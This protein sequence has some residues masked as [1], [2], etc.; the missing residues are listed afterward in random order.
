MDR[1]PPHCYRLYKYRSIAECSRQYTSRI[2]TEGCI[3]YAAPKQFNDPFDCRFCVNMA[4]APLNAFGQLKQDEIKTLAENWLW[5]DSNKD[6]S[7]LSLSEVNDDV[8]MWSHYSDSHAGVCLEFTFQTSEKLHQVQYRKVRPQFYFADCRKQ[9]RDV[10]RFRQSVISSL[11][12]KAEQWA[13]E[14]EWRCIDF[15]S[16]GERPMPDD[17]LSGITF[18]CR[19]S[20]TDE[21]MVRE[22]VQS[23]NRSVTF[24]QAV[25]RDGQFALDIRE[26]D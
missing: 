1:S 16:A 4:D 11:T 10:A 15:G 20:E 22:W 25:Q 2:I 8:L 21:Q 3:Y 14:K 7:V 5:E 18:G 9:E 12:T 17:A 13:Y 24:Y 6:V 19:T 23:A 26:I